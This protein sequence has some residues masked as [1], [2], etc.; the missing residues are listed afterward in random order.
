M[1]AWIADNIVTI[2]ICLV[3]ILIVAGIIYSLIRDKKRGK[4]TCGNNCAHCTMAGSCHTN[5]KKK[6]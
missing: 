2:V 5:T 6:H 4:S 3:L 1:F